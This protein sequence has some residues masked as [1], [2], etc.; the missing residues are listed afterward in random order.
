MNIRFLLPTVM[1]GFAL[2]SASGCAIAAKGRT[3]TVTVRSNPEGATAL[4]NGQEVGKTPLRVNLKRASAYNIELRK[5]GFENAPTVMLPVEN[6]YSKRFLRWGVDYD[7]GAMTDLTPG[8]LVVNL[9]PSLPTDSDGDRY[10]AMTYAVLQADAL[11]SA[12]E[13]TSSDHKF[14][15]AEI[16]KSYAN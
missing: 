1:V 11:F 8:E 14:L 13:I 4:I 16:V 6:E 5:P 12:K 15:V 7:L 3:Q 9:R 10:L 2:V